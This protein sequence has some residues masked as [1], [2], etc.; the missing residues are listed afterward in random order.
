MVAEKDMV[1]LRSKS[2][3]TMVSS[4]SVKNTAQSNPMLALMINTNVLNQ[5]KMSNSSFNSKKSI[6]KK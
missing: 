5:T 2:K 3:D 6:P 1:S 4:K